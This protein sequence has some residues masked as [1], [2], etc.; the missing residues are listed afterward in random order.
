MFKRFWNWIT[1]LFNR[2]K[3]TTELYK[4][5]LVQPVPEKPLTFLKPP[6]GEALYRSGS[7]KW[8]ARTGFEREK[9]VGFGTFRRMK[10]I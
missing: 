6:M 7:Q 1:G 8:I 10:A 5:A 9:Q 2:S 3:R 4:K